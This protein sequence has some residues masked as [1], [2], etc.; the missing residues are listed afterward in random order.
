MLMEKQHCT[1]DKQLQVLVQDRPKQFVDNGA[2]YHV[3][4]AAAAR[5][6]YLP[7]TM[8]AGV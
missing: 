6:K 8:L 1:C 3:K 5:N 7:D 2:Y 4:A